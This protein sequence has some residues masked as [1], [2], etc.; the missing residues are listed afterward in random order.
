MWFTYSVEYPIPH[1]SSPLLCIGNLGR[2]GD[3]P[4]K[5]NHSSFSKR[6]GAKIVAAEPVEVVAVS[7][8]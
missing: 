8:V 5:A 4:G 2:H 6:I 3:S 1:N 7:L